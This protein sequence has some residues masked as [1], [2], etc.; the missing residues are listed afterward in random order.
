MF[1]QIYAKRGANYY[2]EEMGLEYFAKEVALEMH[3]NGIDLMFMYY[4]FEYRKYEPADFLEFMAR[5]Y[6]KKIGMNN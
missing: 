3:K 4:P 6:E 2:P 1:S 5:E